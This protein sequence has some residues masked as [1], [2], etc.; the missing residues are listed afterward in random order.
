MLFAAKL[1]EGIK[2]GEITTSIRIWQRPRVKTNGRYKLDEGE[3][4]VTHIQEIN[5]DDISNEMA[6]ESGFKNKLDLLSTAKHGSGIRVYFIKFF[7]EE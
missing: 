4:V 5:L 1:R 3:V 6:R 7:Y 2:S